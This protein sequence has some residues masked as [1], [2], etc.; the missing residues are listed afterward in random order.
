LNN[1]FYLEKNYQHLKFD[2][3]FEQR[4]MN[5]SFSSNSS[6]QLF[7]Y[8]SF[9]NQL[10]GYKDSTILD[11]NGKIKISG[12]FP[13]YSLNKQS[14]INASGSLTHQFRFY[15]P[16]IIKDNSKINKL[17]GYY[18]GSEFSYNIG[19]L[20]KSYILPIYSSSL[21]LSIGYQTLASKNSYIDI[22]ASFGKSWSTFKLINGFENETKKQER[23]YLNLSLKLGLAK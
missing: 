9:Q 15:L 23:N 21:G 8:R 19:P 6:L 2:G 10:I 22:S 17:N 7:I 5:S 16:R 18:L 1:S 3:S 20:P 14:E 13:I 11:A 4:I 12:L